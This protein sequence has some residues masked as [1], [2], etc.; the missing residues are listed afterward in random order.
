MRVA[1]PEAAAPL[2]L[3]ARQ[4]WCGVCQLLVRVPRMA[5]LKAQSFLHQQDMMMS[6]LP[7]FVDKANVTFTSQKKGSPFVQIN[8]RCTEGQPR[9]H[10]WRMG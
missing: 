9:L 10:G 8:F 5:A 3:T 4:L 2:G 7:S 6:E 1:N